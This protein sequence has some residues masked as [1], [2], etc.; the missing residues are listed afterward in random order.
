MDMCYHNRRNVQVTRSTPHFPTKVTVWLLLPALLLGNA[1]LLA[2]SAYR[3]SPTYSEPAHLAAGISHWQ[4]SSYSLF[5]VNPPGIRMV[6]ALPILLFDPKTNWD[7]IADPPITRPEAQS[8]SSFFS[9]MVPNRYGGLRFALGVH[10]IQLAWG[11]GLF[12]L[13]DATIRQVRCA[14]GRRALV[15]FAVYTWPR[16]CDCARRPCSSDGRGGSLCLLAVAS[17]TTLALCHSSR[18]CPRISGT[19]EV[20]TLSNLS[21]PSYYV[22]CM[23]PGSDKRNTFC[24][25]AA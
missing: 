10:P 2:W 23:P 4:L 22:A 8:E 14:D 9:Q 3:H 15:L 12:R 1:G 11:I 16:G 6:A 18:S 24:G 5:C 20:H 13:G 17:A 19:H 21:P 7:R 25:L